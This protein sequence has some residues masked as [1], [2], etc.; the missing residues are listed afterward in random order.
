MIVICGRIFFRININH[1]E[2]I[3][4]VINMKKYLVTLGWVS[5]RDNNFS[6]VRNCWPFSTLTRPF[7]KF[8]SRKMKKKIDISIMQLLVAVYIH[9]VVTNSWLLLLPNDF[10]HNIF[11]V[12]LW[13]IVKHTI[14]TLT[15]QIRQFLTLVLVFM[16]NDDANAAMAWLQE[17]PRDIFTKLPVEKRYMSK[18]RTMFNVVE[19]MFGFDR[20]VSLLT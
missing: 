6:N 5:L 7:S 4:I 2:T 3:T 8:C 20:N 17:L 16:T 10:D 11:A 12:T 15:R 14:M 19:H 13:T 9:L 18:R 1:F